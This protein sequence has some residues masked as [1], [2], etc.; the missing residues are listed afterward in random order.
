MEALALRENILNYLASEGAAVTG[1]Y[2][3]DLTG[4][5]G[6]YVAGEF[7]KEAGSCVVFGVPIPRG[8]LY[9][10]DGN[11]KVYWRYC[12]TEYRRVDQVSN[13]L[14]QMIEA[15]GG[16]ALPIYGCFPW[17]VE[18]RDFY[19]VLPL[20][21]LAEMAGLGQVSRS[22]LLATRRY[23]TRVLLGGVVTTAGLEPG[24][25]LAEAVCPQDCT[26]CADACPAKA[27]Q[28]DGKVRH[29]K[30]LRYFSASP[31]L[32]ALLGDTRIKSR[33]SFDSLLHVA[34]VDDHG[35]Y[36]CAEC[37]KACPL[38]TASS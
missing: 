9:A 16:R 25:N 28:N 21:R 29:D 18:G 14:C 7:L 20:V 4:V 11:L 33:Y 24:E 17:N 34:G 13:R 2:T 38:N 31:M 37:M 1:I 5:E 3:G 8:V 6:G 32:D 15:E 36:S 23:G 26:A 22:G 12:N 10:G 35:V 19:G 27:I 30:C